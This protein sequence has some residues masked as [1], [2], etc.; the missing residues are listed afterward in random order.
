MKREIGYSLG[1]LVWKGTLLTVLCFIPYLMLRHNNM[2][3]HDVDYSKFTH[4]AEH[5]ILGVSR[6]KVGLVPEILKETL[7]LEG[8]VLNFAFTGLVSPYEEHY[9]ALVR[10]KVRR[11]VQGRP[12]LFILSVNTGN[13]GWSGNF[14]QKPPPIYDLLLVN[15]SPNPDYILR[16][17]NSRTSF[18]FS[19]LQEPDKQP[20][21]VAHRDGWVERT[22]E[23]EVPDEKIYGQYAEKFRSLEL[24]SECLQV[25]SALTTY[26]EQYGE[27]VLVRLPVDETMAA[28]EEKAIPGFDEQLTAFAA[29][30]DAIYLNYLRSGADYVFSDPHHL[31]NTGARA[32]TRQ[33]ADDLHAMGIPRIKTE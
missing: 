16:N 11:N 6:A 22:R 30:H 10:R 24:S 25:L 5:L 32:F 7:D 13:L 8:Q 9:A 1:Q 20:M 2:L 18:L 4:K 21:F 3:K 28:M 19:W 15:T 26:L 31:L 23:S 33:L 17:I 12:A 29:A 14:F 27:V